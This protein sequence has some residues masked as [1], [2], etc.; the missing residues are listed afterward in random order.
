M[1]R[2]GEGTRDDLIRSVLKA[3][4]ILHT[5]RYEGETLRLRDIVARTSI[6]KS[7][8]HRLIRSLERGG[9]VRRVGAE[10]YAPVFKPVVRQ[11][12]RLG[13]ATQMSDSTFSLAVAESIRRTAAANDVELLVVNNRYSPKVALRNADHLIRERVAVVLEFQTYENVAP[14]IASRFVEAGIPLIAIEIPHPG[15]I[16][17]GANNYQAGLIGGRA[18]GRWASQKWEGQVDEILLLE[19]RVAGPLPRARVTGML[20]GVREM[21]PEGE[22]IGVTTYNGRGQFQH[23]F[24]AV[25]RHLKRSPRHRVL[26]MA[27]NDPSALGALRA[28]EESGRESYCA[29]MGQ[30]AIA[31]AREEMRRKGTRLVGSVA[32][33]P[34]R[35]GDELIPLALAVIAGK[36]T[37]PAVYMK[38]VLV[39]PA[40]VDQ[41][42]PLDGHDPVEERVRRSN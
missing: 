2:M 39:T 37:P 7:T 4:D 5:F 1:R 9:L 8:A 3:C 41:I 24:D 40:N 10:S 36:P 14:I 20:A 30:N 11:R 17:F 12:P 31:E 38:H 22:R 25:R 18:L 35:Y 34:E 15:A 21:L 26:V 23:S 32:Y 6:G 13:L 33:F 29:I 42:Y 28:F 27:N 16:Y 19:E